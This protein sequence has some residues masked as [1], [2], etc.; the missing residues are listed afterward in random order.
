MDITKAKE[1]GDKKLSGGFGDGGPSLRG[2]IRSII[3]KSGMAL[4]IDDVMEALMKTD[5][6]KDSDGKPLK[7]AKVKTALS[8]LKRADIL[9]RSV[10]ET[11]KGNIM[12][13]YTNPDKGKAEEVDE[14]ESDE[15]DEDDED[16]DA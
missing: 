6:K 10:E 7:K 3:E 13:F 9:C 5:F 14:D 16:L 4:N 15:S 11:D 12:H 1:I 2:E 8:N